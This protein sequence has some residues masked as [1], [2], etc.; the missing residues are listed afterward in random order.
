MGGASKNSYLNL[1]SNLVVLC[2][3]MN[4]AIEASADQAEKALENGWKVSRYIDPKTVP[5]FDAKLG[6][7]YMLDDNYG[8]QE[9]RGI[10]ESLS[11]YLPGSI[12]IRN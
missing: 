6:R 3:K 7:W 12:T 11:G 8:R 4:N 9:I 5:V 1:P 10:N 2:S